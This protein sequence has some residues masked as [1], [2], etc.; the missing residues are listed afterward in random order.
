MRNET[1]ELKATT[2]TLLLVRYKLSHIIANDENYILCEVLRSLALQKNLI[3]I[4]LLDSDLESLVLLMK[5]C[6]DI[7]HT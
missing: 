2:Q 1:G 3:D 5:L 4:F 6:S 7:I